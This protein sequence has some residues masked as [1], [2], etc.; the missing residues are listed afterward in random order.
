LWCSNNKL[1]SLNVSGCIALS[2]LSCG[3]NQLNAATLNALF[4]MLHS[5][6]VNWGYKSVI[7]GNNPGTL[8]C[9]QS[10]ATNKGWT[11][12]NY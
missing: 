12:N 5:N 7:I 1:T 2:Y 9:D 8:S 6:Y 4:G 11:I 10:I 3:N